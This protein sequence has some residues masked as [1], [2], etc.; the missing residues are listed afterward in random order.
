MQILHKTKILAVLLLILGVA[1]C[2][3]KSRPGGAA[4]GADGAD[5]N[6]GATTSAGSFGSGLDSQ[7]LN[8]PNPGPGAP[9]TPLS[10]VVFRFD[11]DSADIRP[12]DHVALRAHGN[13]LRQNPSVR[14]MVGGHT[15]ERGTRE[16]NMALGERRAKA[17]ATFLTSSGA[18]PS[19]LEVVSY[20][21][22]KPMSAEESENAWAEN[23]RVELNYPKR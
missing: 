10:V 6:G 7:S 19:Q 23:R 3:S 9:G 13:Y 4:D 11:Y 20:G 22:E 8:G 2:T 5:G 12:E 15:D 21:E 17:V 14:I 16:Y 18:T 1:A